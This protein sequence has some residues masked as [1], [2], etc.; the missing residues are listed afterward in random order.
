MRLTKKVRKIFPMRKYLVVHGH[1]YQPPRENPWIE[2]IERQ[3]SAQP[4]HDWNERINHEC[5]FPN[6]YSRILDSNN[7]IV[8]IVNNYRSISFNFGPTLL[9][10]LEEH[11]RDVYERILQADK[12]SQAQFGGHGAAI[13]Q[14]YNHII[15][16]LANER[17]QHTQIRWGISD[18]RYRFK[19]EPESIWLPETAINQKTLNILCDYP[20]KYIIL[21]PYQALRVRPLG[22]TEEKAWQNV[23]RG[24]I[25]TRQPYRCFARNENGEKIQDKYI[26]IFF[27]HGDLAKGV[28][29]EHLLRNAGYLAERIEDVFNGG[30]GDRDK[31]VSI[32]TDGETYGHHEKYG[33]MGLAYL[34][35]VEAQLR[36]I[37]PTNFGAY[38]ANHPP[39]MEV[40][41]KPGPNGE[42]T[43]WSCA[44]G[45]GRWYR[46]C[47]CKTGGDYRWTQAWRT[48]L[49]QA[50]DRL[51]DRLAILTEEIGS[52]LFNDVWAARDDFIQVIL[53][54]SE[55]NVE[56]FLNTHASH[57]LT[58]KEKIRAIKLMEM[59]RQT[60]LMY[61]SCGWFFTELSGI[62]TVQIIK[63]A[64]RAI[65]LAESLLPGMHLEAAFLSE[66]RKAKSNIPE[67]KD[68]EWIYNHFVKPTVVDFDKVVNHYAI[69]KMFRTF[70][71]DQEADKTKHIY[72]YVVEDLGEKR[73]K[74]D[75]ANFLFGQVAVKSKITWEEE[76]F[77]YTL[78][79]IGHGEKL[80]TH[81]R[82]LDHDLWDF[83]SACE[84]II[85]ATHNSD[86]F[87]IKETT[88]KIWGGTTLTLA[89]MFYDERHKVAEALIQNQ[90]DE[91]SH[92]YREIFEKYKGQNLTIAK[93]EV[94]LPE[95]VIVPAK[96]TLSRQML[97]ELIRLDGVTDVRAYKRAL[98]AARTAQ[99]LHIELDNEKVCAHFQN[100]IENQLLKLYL[101]FNRE[102]ARRVI[103]MIELADRLKLCLPQS[104]IQNRLFEILNFR[105][106]PAIEKIVNGKAG[107]ELYDAVNDTLR[108]AFRFN[109]NIKIYK[110]RLREFEEKISQ[111]PNYWP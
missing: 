104:R 96:I 46:D 28:S 51:R 89:D 49:R 81:V 83:D 54:R 36:D 70:H 67:Y 16:P 86:E 41:L 13:A 94:P 5:Y 109:F 59:Q 9:S 71:P 10:W 87:E 98:D 22:A 29:F 8:D 95:A 103:V 63:Y 101:N 82:R 1:F 52:S 56:N 18:F 23:E 72:M 39:T 91:V 15:M 40:E 35:N 32:A 111:D 61:T 26:D 43:A 107:R 21:S 74:S 106:L 2:A 27:Y 64:A 45:V 47:G 92:T 97:E 7:R 33:D 105:V 31:I 55:E 11:A 100:N 68:G 42:G 77:A 4:Y 73:H 30:E 99:R 69:S 62:E 14:C 65:Q 60:Q 57:E 75:K 58:H 93:M 44:H 80:H 19:R 76:R 102:N 79:N 84:K 108:I 3:P 37:V 50:L 25:D 53:D 88:Q 78:I 20:F 110:D 6:A 38:L 12:E 34:L 48:P 85:Q 90:L 24:N 66:L 17:D